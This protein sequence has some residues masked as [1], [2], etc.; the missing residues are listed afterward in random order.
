MHYS[1]INLCDTTNGDGCRVSLFV[2]GCTLHCKGCFNKEAWDFK[3][4][5]PFDMNEHGRLILRSLRMPFINGLSVL[6]GDPFEPQNIDTVTDLSKK[7]K[8]QYPEKDIWIWT[9]RKF[10]QVKDLECLK[11]IDVLIVNPFIERLSIHG[12]YY[13][14][15]NQQLLR[16][17]GHEWVADDSE[18][19]V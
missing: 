12:R 11:Y 6:G 1:G 2:S 17:H 9:G 16:R 19:T 18:A 13:G 4:G 5:K 8:L 3:Y 14:S 15:S 10:N 7:A